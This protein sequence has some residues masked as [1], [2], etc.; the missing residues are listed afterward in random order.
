MQKLSFCKKNCKFFVK[1]FKSYIF[2]RNTKIN[3]CK[4]FAAMREKSFFFVETKGPLPLICICSHIKDTIYVVGTFVN[5]PKCSY[6]RCGRGR[7][8]KRSHSPHPTEP[9]SRLRTQ[10][11]SRANRTNLLKGLSSEM[12]G[13]IK[14][15]SIESSLF[16]AQ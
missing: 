12:D 13:G 10:L 11:E 3:F 6:Q 7:F 1:F 5:N 15:V 16:S 2:S 14:V 4:D 9:Q 8:A